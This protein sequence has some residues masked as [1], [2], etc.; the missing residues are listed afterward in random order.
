MPDVQS[1]PGIGAVEAERAFEPGHS[2]GGS[3]RPHQ[4][5]P[6]DLIAIGIARIDLERTV[7]LPECEIIMSSA[8]M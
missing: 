5:V 1:C 7:D 2:L 4:D 3:A 6:R 8:Y